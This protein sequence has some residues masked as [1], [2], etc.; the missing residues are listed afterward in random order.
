MKNFVEL[1]GRTVIYNEKNFMAVCR[2]KSTELIGSYQQFNLEIID[3]LNCTKISLNNGDEL[4]L[5]FELEY[6]SY[7]HDIVSAAYYI[8]W[9][10]IF[11][12]SIISKARI[13]VPL[14]GLSLVKYVKMLL[15][16]TQYP[17]MVVDSNQVN[18]KKQ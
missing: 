10:L 16:E 14:E 7:E 6:I 12:E 17:E 1:I 5:G 11:N 2:L 18:L 8:S 3:A 9:R 4:D 15:D 13:Y